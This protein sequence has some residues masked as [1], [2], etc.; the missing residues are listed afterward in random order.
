MT[1]YATF[2]ATFKVEDY[3]LLKKK[4]METDLYKLEIEE[5]GEDHQFLSS[6]AILE[7][8]TGVDDK[9]CHDIGVEFWASTCEL[10]SEDETRLACNA[11]LV[12]T[13]AV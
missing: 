7:L 12:Y 13:K 2:S 6:T 1:T 4:Y 9:A 5:Y 10:D 11:D 3:E 8:L